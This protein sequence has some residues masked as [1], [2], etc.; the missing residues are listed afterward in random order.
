MQNGGRMFACLGLW[1]DRHARNGPEQMACDEAILAEA[2]GPVLRIFRWSGPW[3]S[4]GYFVPLQRAAAVRPDLPLC[5]RWTGGGVVVHE[6]DFTFSLA[7]PRGESWASM[8]PAESYRVL[9]EAVARALGALGVSAALAGK[10]AGAGEECFASPVAHD[11]MTGGQKIAGGAQRRTRSGLL[12]QG[13]IQI[14]DLPSGLAEALASQLA[15]EVKAW[16]PPPGL[17]ERVRA[18]HRAKYSREDFTHL[19]SLP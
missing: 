7:V 12:H 5:R 15:E 17:E 13:S 3:V 9:H 14:P 16:T 4:A 2:T 1:E 10:T 8:R 6:G 18:L 11:L 19:S